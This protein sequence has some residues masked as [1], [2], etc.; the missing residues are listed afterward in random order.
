MNV[1][2]KI[3]NWGDRNHPTWLDYI[4]IA[5][6]ITLIWKGVSFAVNLHA[7]TRL[8]EDTQLGAALS[9]SLLAHLIIVLHI[10]GGL[11]IALG[12]HTRMFCLLNLPILLVAVFFVNLPQNIFA[13]YSEFWFSCAVLLGLVC[14]LIEG[15]GVLSIEGRKKEKASA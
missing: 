4:R 8:M 11:L 3:Q 6:G 9:I 15:D 1:F 5:L 12:T 10:I 2:E 13:P 14:F 7:F